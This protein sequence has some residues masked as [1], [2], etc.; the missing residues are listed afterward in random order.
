MFPTAFNVEAKISVVKLHIHLTLIINS[1]A[2][3]LLIFKFYRFHSFQ[4]NW[5]KFN[6]IQLYSFCNLLII[7]LSN[8]LWNI[9]VYY[10]FVKIFRWLILRHILV[11]LS[12][13]QLGS[14]NFPYLIWTLILS[15]SA[16][17]ICYIITNIVI[18][19]LLL[20]PPFIIIWVPH[21]FNLTLRSIIFNLVKLRSL[22]K[23][24]TA[25]FFLYW[26]LLTNS[27]SL[28]IK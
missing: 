17:I 15:N 3:P 20:R 21:H 16:S 2:Y 19:Q 26:L 14:L 18:F 12:I 6:F 28:F 7:Y 23:Q 11:N 22:I 9:A 4:F 8:I 13:F 5:W 24:E 27:K 25:R 10:Y 1:H